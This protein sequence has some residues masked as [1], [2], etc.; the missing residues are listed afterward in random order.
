MDRATFSRN[1]TVGMWETARRFLTFPQVFCHHA[2]KEAG[3]FFGNGGFGDIVF[4]AQGNV[5]KLAPEAFV[6]LIGIV[7]DLRWTAG[8]RIFSATDFLP[9][10]PRPYCWAASTR[11]L[12]RWEFTAFVMP[13][14]YCFSPLE[15]SLAQGQSR[16]RTAVQR[17]V[18]RRSR[19]AAKHEMG[20]V[21][22]LLL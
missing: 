1:R 21:L 17:P 16:T 4:G 14:C 7:H 15:F 11:S 8:F 9:T 2:P 13:V 10:T 3:Q 5:V 18:Q 20:K 12:R 6:S 19:Q 22:N